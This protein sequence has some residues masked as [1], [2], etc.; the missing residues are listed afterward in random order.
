MRWLPTQEVQ[1]WSRRRAEL[2]LR[3]RHSSGANRQASGSSQAELPH[4]HAHPLVPVSWR[5]VVLC[6]DHHQ[7][8]CTSVSCWSAHAHRCA[9]VVLQVGE[10][11]DHSAAQVQDRPDTDRERPVHLRR[12]LPRRS[13]AG[14]PHD[15]SILLAL[16]T[17]LSD[18][19]LSAHVEMAQGHVLY[20]VDHAIAQLL[21]T[22][23]HTVHCTACYDCSHV[24]ADAPPPAPEGA[25]S[26]GLF[27]D[28]GC[29][30]MPCR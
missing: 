30:T 23:Q 19:S 1:G 15:P 12:L 26:A 4:G 22:S 9:P 13:G 6:Y 29:L 10:Q 11:P 16:I 17:I 21:V 18:R 20:H 2:Q 24:V 7:I 3:V 8:V 28:L 27:G 14:E 25:T 5:P